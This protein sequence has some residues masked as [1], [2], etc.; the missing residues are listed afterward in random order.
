MRGFEQAYLDYRKRAPMILPIPVRRTV[1]KVLK[2]ED[3]V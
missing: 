2:D 1:T 3:I